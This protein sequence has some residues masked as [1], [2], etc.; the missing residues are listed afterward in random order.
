MIQLVLDHPD[1]GHWQRRRVQ[2][3]QRY[4]VR[5]GEISWRMPVDHFAIPGRP[6]LGRRLYIYGSINWPHHLYW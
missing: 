5:E 1:A 3:Q 2:T 4:N 6:T